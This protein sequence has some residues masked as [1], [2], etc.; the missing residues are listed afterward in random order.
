MNPAAE[1]IIGS[2]ESSVMGKNLAAVWP[3]LDRIISTS[4]DLSHFELTAGKKSA[5]RNLDVSVSTLIGSKHKMT[6]RL[7]VLRDIQ[8]LKNTQRR[9]EKLYNEEHDLRSH[10]EEE[11]QKRS[12]YSRA[13]VHELRTPLTSIIISSDILEE[14]VKDYTQKRLVQ[15]I[16]RASQNL[17]QRVNELFELARGEVGLLNLNPGPCDMQQLMQEITAEMTPVAANKGLVLK[18]ETQKEELILSGDRSRL[19]QV[20]LNLV[21]NAV[22]YTEKGEILIKASYYNT[23]FLLVQVSDTGPGISQ[24]QLVNLFDPYRRHQKEW[25]TTGLGL[26]LAL[27]KIFVEL[28]KG[29]IWA[30]STLGKG[31][32]ISFIIPLNLPLQDGPANI[33]VKSHS[34]PSGV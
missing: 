15:G 2:S 9:L 24:E 21:S 6:G 3:E 26:G 20:I 1:K 27:S 4:N 34:S 28:H 13:V 18:S 33:E 29:K 8:E 7:V 23:E 5:A 12:Q 17:N 30:D 10:L 19:K 11:M 16:R 32:T 22:K 25:K 31:T 14:Q